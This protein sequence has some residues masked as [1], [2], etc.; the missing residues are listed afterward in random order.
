MSIPSSFM[1][2]FA[3]STSLLTSYTWAQEKSTARASSDSQTWGAGAAYL[4][5]FELVSWSWV[6]CWTST[7][8]RVSQL[9]RMEVSKLCCELWGVQMLCRMGVWLVHGV[10]IAVGW[11]HQR[12]QRLEAESTSPVSGSSSSTFIFVC[13]HFHHHHR[14]RVCSRLPVHTVYFR[15]FDSLLIMPSRPIFLYFWSYGGALFYH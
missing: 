4:L 11:L 9:C 14:I 3:L 13:H 6:L 15:T 8:G 12:G 2:K 7:S 10:F 1:F 5:H